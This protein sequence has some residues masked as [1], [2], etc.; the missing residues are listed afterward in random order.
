MEAADRFI[1]ESTNEPLAIWVEDTGE[2]LHPYPRYDC[3]YVTGIIKQG[4]I[5][6]DDEL[7]LIGFGVH[8][9]VTA[10]FL[11]GNERT[12]SRA[13]KGQLLPLL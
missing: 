7:D 4:V 12:L 11:R 10:K 2:S 9:K 8:Q 6:K 3:P 13:E 5:F 1:K